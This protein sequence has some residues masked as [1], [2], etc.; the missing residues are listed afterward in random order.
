MVAKYKITV[1]VLA[2]NRE[3][4]ILNCLSSLEQQSFHYFKIMIIDDGSTDNTLNKIKNFARDSIRDISVY[5]INHC[6]VA[7]ARNHALELLET[8][9][10]CFV[11]SDDTVAS[12]MLELLYNKAYNDSADIVTCGLRYVYKYHYVDD[13]PTQQMIDQNKYASNFRHPGGILYKSDI[14]RNN[15]IKFE[16]SSNSVRLLPHNPIVFSL[17]NKIYAVEEILYFY[18]Q[19][20]KCTLNNQEP[21]Y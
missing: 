2:Y 13:I 15:N 8:E 4:H 10:F 5:S 18:N 19:T 14:W 6:G 3:E 16:K 9:Y 1:I 21:V 7:D 12:N 11:D 17:T 20:P